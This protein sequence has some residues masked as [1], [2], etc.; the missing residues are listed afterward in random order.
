VG[1]EDSATSEVRQ[2][3]ELPLASLETYLRTALPAFAGP[4][5]VRQFSGGQ[6][7]P[8]YRLDTPSRSYVL[9]RKPPGALLP[10]AHAVEREYRVM[11]ALAGTKV[12]VPQCYALCLDPSVV[13]TPF[14]IMEHVAGRI[15]WDPSLPAVPAPERRLYYSALVSA[16]ADLHRLDYLALG[17]GDFGRPGG[18]LARQLGRWSMQYHED[19]AAGRVTEL[20]RLMAWLEAH[21]PAEEPACLVHG[22]CRFDNAV[23]EARA[24]RLLAFLDWEL[25]TLGDPLADFA[26]LLL[27][28]RLPGLGVRGLRG[29]DLASLALPAEQELV[30][31]YCAQAGRD[32]LPHLAYYIAFNLFRLAAILHGIRGRIIRGTAASA[33]ARAHAAQVEAVAALG[34]QATAG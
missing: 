32:G 22:D 25:S 7:N 33:E 17:L 10:G 2:G 15:F 18:Y 31:L 30:A 4:L 26:Y 24:P 19:E 13:G 21:R 1:S 16:L 29:R 8:T 20:E 12:P 28:Y 34:W 27:L 3:F 9:R 5:T 11:H 6:S 23:F 14:F